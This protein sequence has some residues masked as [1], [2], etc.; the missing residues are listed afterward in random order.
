[1]DT[2]Y[3][4]KNTTSLGFEEL[5]LTEVIIIHAANEAN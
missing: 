3:A 2:F 1:M 4:A 5:Q